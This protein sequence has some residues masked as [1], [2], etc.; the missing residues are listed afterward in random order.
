M[1]ALACG[2]ADGTAYRTAGLCVKAS[3]SKCRRQLVWGDAEAL[4]L[5]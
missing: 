2:T 1:Q 4:K 3:E 5:A